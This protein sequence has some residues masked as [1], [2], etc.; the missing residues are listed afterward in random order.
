MFIV[1]TLVLQMKFLNV[2]PVDRFYLKRYADERITT[3]WRLWDNLYNYDNAVKT[4]A[5]RGV[6]TNTRYFR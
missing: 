6:K 5:E 4:A 1:I 2:F 3:K